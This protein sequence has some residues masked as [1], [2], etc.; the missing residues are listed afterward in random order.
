HCWG[1]VKSF[2]LL[3]DNYKACLQNIKF[4]NLS[5]NMRD[6]VRIAQRLGFSDIWI[7]SVCIVQDSKKDWATEAPKMG[8]VYSG[9]VCTIASTGSSSGDGGCFHRRNCLS[10]S[11]C[12]I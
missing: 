4:S 9:A 7:D 1:G 5:R 11:P 6:A 8:G 10:L 12:K 3:S 2:R